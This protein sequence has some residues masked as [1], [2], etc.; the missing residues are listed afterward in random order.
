LVTFVAR[1]F[2]A[3]LAAIR[4]GGSLVPAVRGLAYV[5][6]VVSVLVFN[7][8]ARAFVYFQF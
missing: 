6:L 3:K 7:N 8:E 1:G 4:P 5:L 2:V